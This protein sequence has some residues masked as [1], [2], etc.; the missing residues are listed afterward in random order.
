MADLVIHYTA[1]HLLA[2]AAS[3]PR[4]RIL[5]Y[6]GNCVPDLLYKFFY[7]FTAS[8]TWY[9]EP[10]H[11]PLM[12]VV[13]SYAMAFLF[14][15][16]LRRTAFGLLLAGSLCHV[17]IDLGKDYMGMGVILWTFPFSMNLAELGWYDTD[18]S[19]L[20]WPWCLAIIGGTE[21]VVWM[22]RRAGRNP[23]SKLPTPN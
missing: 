23:N 12:L 6:L 8:P 4:K 3:D 21:A 19:H 7:F 11:S 10:T 13:I 14:E 15:A 16:P 9:A 18:A 20:A 17:F 1:A 22:V 5:F 2:R